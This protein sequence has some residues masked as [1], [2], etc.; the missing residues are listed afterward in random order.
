MPANETTPSTHELRPAETWQRYL[1]AVACFVA[2][3][4]L[5]L[6]L[7]MR[8]EPSAAV[9]EGASMAPAFLGEHWEVIC[10][11]CQFR[12]PR[13]ESVTQSSLGVI[14]PNCA[15]RLSDAQQQRVAADRVRIDSLRF[16][17]QPP[18]RWDV[19][20]IRRGGMWTVKRIVGLPGEEVS[21]RDGNVLINGKRC[22]FDLATWRSQAVLV[23]DDR[24]R[25]L[26][27]E[28]PSWRWKA[29]PPRQNWTPWT[30]WIPT[31]NGYRLNSNQGDNE[32]AP[33]LYVHQRYIFGLMPQPQA[34]PVLDEDHYNAGP[35]R[36]LNA[37]GDLA[38]R[39][40]VQP[41]KCG[42]LVLAL[43]DGACWNDA[44]WSQAEQVWQLR[45]SD[46]V[47]ASIPAKELTTG[48]LE[49]ITRDGQLLLAV[50][51]QLLL[52][53][54][55]PASSRENRSGED[56]PVLLDAPA[57]I[58]A[59]GEIELNDVQLLRDIVYLSPQQTTNLWKAP[60]LNADEYFVLGDNSPV[61][62]DSRNWAEFCIERREI[63]GA[64]HK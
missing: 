28:V 46:V 12:W 15:E 48:E 58:S 61:S 17:K 10:S 60:R 63:R 52:T 5:L 18:Q 11:A 26:R 53:A 6:V 8:R 40:K 41:A 14:C 36:K 47:L 1:V 38:L 35:S 50:N 55:L 21:L 62:V 56:V 7:A 13:E 37:V 2:S 20:A 49:F 32:L 9:I 57:R 23:H 59:R 22:D 29:P 27:S 45:Q 54:V 25:Y 64:V 31:D 39:L 42:E 33:L 43:Y 4:L 30:N 34:S 24:F 3:V 19:V 51:R 16:Q 44:R